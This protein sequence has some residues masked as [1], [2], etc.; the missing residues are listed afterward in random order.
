MALEQAGL[1]FEAQGAQQ[2]LSTLQQAQQ[3]TQG[4]GQAAQA[5]SGHA[6]GLGSA[7]NEVLTGALRRVGEM[8]TNFAI[9]GVGKIIN[10]LPQAINAANDWAE[11]LDSVG[12][13]L[14]TTSEESAALRVAVEG[15][16]GD[17]DK[18][19]SQLAFMQKGLETAKGK[20][21]PTGLELEKLGIATQDAHGKSIPLMNLLPVIAD[22]F[23]SMPDGLEKT[24]A[25]MRVFG[26][27]GKD[28][29][30][31]MSGLA[32]GGLAKADARAKEFGLSLSGEQVDASI[33]Y[34]RQ[35]K[36]LDQA[37]QGVAVS[38]G[39]KLLPIVGPLLKQFI[40]FVEAHLP[41]V[42]DAIGGAVNTLGG[43]FNTIR[44]AIE[45]V[46]AIIGDFIG[47]FQYGFDFDSFEGLADVLTRAFG[48]EMGSAISG[49][50]DKIATLAYTV[51]TVVGDFINFF[52]YGFDFDSFEGLADILNRI[53][54]PEVGAAIRGIIDQIAT[55]AYTIG[56]LVAGLQQGTEATNFFSQAWASLQ[57][58][59]SAI[60]A[61]ILSIVQTVFGN[62]QTF[63]TDHSDQIK[64]FVQS[65]WTAI[66]AIFSTAWEIIKIIVTVAVTF[67]Q[68]TIV[69]IFQSIAAFLQAHSDQ[70]QAILNGAWN[71]IKSVIQTAI[72]LIQGILNTVL[73]LIK[74]DWQGAWDAILKTV[75]DLWNN[76][77]GPAGIIQ[78][79]INLVKSILD[80]GL[81][82]IGTSWDQLWAGLGATVTS[83]WNGIKQG[84][85]NSINSVIDLING[86]IGSANN[87]LGTLGLP[88][89]GLIQHVNL[90][91]GGPGYGATVNNY[92]SYS[93]SFNMPVT[94]SAS[95]GNIGYNFAVMEA[96]AG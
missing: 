64:T 31:V 91:G 28:L 30:D 40:G 10:A 1:S 68:N 73:A 81:A 21:G 65:T 54:G 66:Q 12:D 35:M 8:A 58:S 71:T 46:V 27:S 2:F 3:G 13:V 15:V 14:G 43:V 41:D 83:V 37:F 47:F 76:L 44:P 38:I 74:G 4:F 50:V 67:V 69:P 33:A 34:G 7:L 24:E 70:I 53:F 75:T 20:I 51:G 17:T 39:E 23:N 63:I 87:I 59:L 55:F 84:I 92:N 89:I 88:Q 26:K 60:G 57:T 6:T 82:A 85:Q 52:Q 72:N 22:K 36:E 77:T 48:P 95:V 62:I 80:L 78:S 29:S 5:A 25:M 86:M 9:D 49:I 90:M 45:A 61:A 42:M 19:A 32:E 11:K 79:G 18:F 16:G 94:T 93:P 96:M 56:G